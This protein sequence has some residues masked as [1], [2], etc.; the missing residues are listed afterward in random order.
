MALLKFPPLFH[1]QISGE[2]EEDVKETRS[3]SNIMGS[4]KK[5][6]WGPP[7]YSTPFSGRSLAKSSQETPQSIHSEI[8]TMV[9]WL[10]ISF[11][12]LSFWWVG[13]ICRVLVLKA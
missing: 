8:H 6:P 3:N 2:V 12:Y 1:K 5:M 10:N 4:L 9:Q 11:Y 7:L 13:M